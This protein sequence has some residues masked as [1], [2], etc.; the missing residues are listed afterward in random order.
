MVLELCATDF[1]RC[2]EFSSHD[3]SLRNVHPQNLPDVISDNAELG[4]N[5]ICQ[6]HGLSQPQRLNYTPT[7]C[8]KFSNHVELSGE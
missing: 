1:I 5:E 7:D 3:V 2:A 6:M 4:T 8:T